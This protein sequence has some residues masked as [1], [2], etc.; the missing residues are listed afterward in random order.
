[1]KYAINDLSVEANLAPAKLSE[2][3]RS[4]K[5]MRMNASDYF[6]VKANLPKAS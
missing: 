1:M 4:Q 5:I 3:C 6:S 2:A